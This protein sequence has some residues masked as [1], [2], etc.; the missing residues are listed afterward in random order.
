MIRLDKKV[1][2]MLTFVCIRYVDLPSLS[3]VR[4]NYS[5][6][7][8]VGGALGGRVLLKTAAIICMY[9]IRMATAVVCNT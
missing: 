4:N 1:H 9:R 6:H 8:F 5:C 3:N 2:F 7:A